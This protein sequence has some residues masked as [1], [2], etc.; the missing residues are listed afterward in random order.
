LRA[1]GEKAAH[2]VAFA[3]GGRIVVVVPRLI[4]TLANDWADTTLCL[5]EGDWVDELTGENAGSGER[6]VGE[7]LR[8]FPVALLS[9][10]GQG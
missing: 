3:R 4:I 8:Q 1:R 9:R 2:V 6:T 7:L 5:P 10:K